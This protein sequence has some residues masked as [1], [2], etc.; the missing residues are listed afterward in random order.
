[1]L[2]RRD[3][4]EVYEKFLYSRD[5]EVGITGVQGEW[6]LEVRAGLAAEA[7]SSYMLKERGPAKNGIQDFTRTH[8][9]IPQII[10]VDDF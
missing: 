3:W 6:L 7:R 9:K 1:M 10:C 8:L 5:G 4:G 2:G